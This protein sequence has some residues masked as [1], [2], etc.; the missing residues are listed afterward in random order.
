MIERMGVNEHER[1][2]PKM[3]RKLVTQRSLPQY[4]TTVC[5]RWL[6]QRV[7]HPLLLVCVLPQPT[8]QF[9]N[10]ADFQVYIIKMSLITCA[11]GFIIGPHL[12]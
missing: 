7:K 8:M 3:W 12:A 4:T 2:L 6:G 11:T 1:G 9:S 5:S 10:L